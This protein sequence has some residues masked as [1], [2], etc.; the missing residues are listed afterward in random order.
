MARD[1]RDAQRGAGARER[2]PQRGQVRVGDLGGTSEEPTDR[3][4]EACR[5]VG[6][7]TY[8]AGKG[9]R[10]YLRTEAFEKAGIGVVWQQFDP[11][12]VPYPQT[13]PGFVPGLSVLDCLFNVGPEE[14][15][16]LIRAAWAP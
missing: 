10:N 3:L 12:S 15:A 4:V 8:I 5:A 9:G 1:H 7:K 16:R 6:A 11:A 2:V 13:G 14:A